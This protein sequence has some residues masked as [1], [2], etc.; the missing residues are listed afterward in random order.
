MS[1]TLLYG[2]YLCSNKFQRHSSRNDNGAG[3]G[4]VAPIPTPPRLLKIILIPVPFKKLNG[5]GRGGA[6]MGN[7]QTH[8]APPSLAFFFKK[9]N[10]LL[11][12]L[13]TLK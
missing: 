10:L 8:P 13:I 11:N 9:K 7:S 4:R 5:A 2:T 6:G 12:F 1:F 3:S